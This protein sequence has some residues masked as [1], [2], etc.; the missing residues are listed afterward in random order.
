MVKL[1]EEGSSAKE[2]NRRL[3]LTV[4]GREAVFLPLR[5]VLVLRQQAK[6]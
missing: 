1:R 4:A 3:Y 5:G 2:M 6:N